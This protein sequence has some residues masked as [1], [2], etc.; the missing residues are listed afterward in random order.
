MDRTDH[1]CDTDTD[2]SCY[3]GTDQSADMDF[4]GLFSRQFS[5]IATLYISA[6]GPAELYSATRYGK[7]FILKALKEEYR[8]DPIHTLALAKEFEIGIFLEHPNIRRTIGLEDV[9]GLGRVIVL[10]YIDGQSLESILAAGK[11]SVSAARNIVRRVADA[12]AYMHSKQV[13][14]RDLK[15]SNILV[16]H[17]GEVVK[18]IDFNLS[19]S[20]DFVV[21]KNPAGSRKYMAPEQMQPGAVPT[22]AADIYS[23]GVLM[24]EL[25]AA[26]GD[27]LLAEVAE[28]CSNADP[29]RRPTEVSALKL[30]GAQ[31]SVAESVSGFLASKALT[32]IMGAICTALAALIVFLLI[33]R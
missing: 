14:H 20:N 13:Y 18:I 2:S 7:R 25:A 10:E 8:N 9:D 26:S 22:A 6:H 3:L 30:P 12:L 32:W 23:L 17:G 24:A 31:S 33:S 19:D 5:N 4:G 27:P 1:S 15:P 29:T 21:L 28:K 16:T 11:L